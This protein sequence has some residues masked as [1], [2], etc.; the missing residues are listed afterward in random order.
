MNYRNTISLAG[1]TF[2]AF[3]MPAFAQ[4]DA[5]QQRVIGKLANDIRKE[6]IT[7]TNYGVFDTVSF[8]IGKGQT[9]YKV[10]LKGYASRPTLKD[11]AERVV[12]KIEGVESVEN[13]IEVL[14][15]SRMDDDVR[16][17]VYR[18][19]YEHPTLSRYNPNRGMPLYRDPGRLRRARTV[20]ISNDPPI[21]NHPISIIVKN[22]KVNLEG[23]VDNE[24]DKNIAGIQANTV[25]GVFGVT[26]N[27][28]IAQQK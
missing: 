6:I 27:L 13:Q 18:A 4:S 3:C 26:N 28:Q 19:I 11:S 7:L 22:G 23:V 10:V 5:D 2:A 9:D 8:T 17:R 20:G 25:S 14:P 15:V 21:G 1:L 24:G 16:L 12:K